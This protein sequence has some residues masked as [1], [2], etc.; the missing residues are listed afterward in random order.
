MKLFKDHQKKGQKVI[1][2]LPNLR[3]YAY[4]M[5][6]LFFDGSAHHPLAHRF[7]QEFDQGWQTRVSLGEPP[8]FTKVIR[9]Y[10]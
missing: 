10:F 7:I 3:R 6:N 2:T 8:L 5:T 1:K 4:F 9:A